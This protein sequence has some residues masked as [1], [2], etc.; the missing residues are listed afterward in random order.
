MLPATAGA[1]GGSI[2]SVAELRADERVLGGNITDHLQATA[3]EHAV[4]PYLAAPDRIW[5]HGEL[6]D[7][8]GRTANALRSLGVQPG[9]RVLFSAV[10]G[11]DFPALFLA[12]MKI[13]AVA[14]PI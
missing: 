9:Q 10:D 13:G 6:F 8:V 4:R 2:M 11:I 12:I 14:L 3:R 5:S 1:Q 7:R